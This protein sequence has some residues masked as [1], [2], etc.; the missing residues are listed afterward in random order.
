MADHSRKITIALRHASTLAYE[1]ALEYDRDLQKDM[2]ELM[3]L[4]L[5]GSLNEEEMLAWSITQR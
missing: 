5:N 3:E 2:Q 4:R 1:T